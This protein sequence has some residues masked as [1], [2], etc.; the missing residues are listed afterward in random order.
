ML[1]RIDEK[2]FLTKVTLAKQH[3]TTALLDRV[4]V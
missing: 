2:L 4:G 3:R 1:V